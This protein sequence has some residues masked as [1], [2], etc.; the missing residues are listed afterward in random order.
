MIKYRK[1]DV[2]RNSFIICCVIDYVLYYK[3]LKS[4]SDKGRI[5]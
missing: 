5:G 2:K 3:S 1:Q 4:F